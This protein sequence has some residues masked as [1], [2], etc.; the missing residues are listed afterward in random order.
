MKIRTTGAAA[1]LPASKVKSAHE[2]KV[3]LNSKSILKTV[4]ARYAPHPIRAR[5]LRYETRTTQSN[6]SVK[7]YTVATTHDDS[8]VTNGLFE[9]LIALI[10]LAFD[11]R[12][13]TIE[14]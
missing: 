9:T 2:A 12:E 8:V 6:I 1:V 7:S 13:V 4:R 14:V 11:R 3:R 10:A 5:P